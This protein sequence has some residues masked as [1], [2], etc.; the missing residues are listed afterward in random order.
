MNT[1]LN[2]INPFN[3]KEIARYNIDQPSTVKFKLERSKEASIRWASVSIRQRA[4]YLKTLADYLQKNKAR[5]AAIATAEM[6]KPLT[7]SITELEKSA[8]TLEYY[9]EH[10]AQFLEPELV[11][12]EAQKSFVSFQPLGT[13]LAIM[14]WNFPYW[15]VFRAMGPILLGGNTML[16]KHA[17]NVTGCAIAIEKALLEAG[18]PEGIFQTL[19]VPSS[20][21]EPVIASKYIHAVTFTG[22]TA[23]GAKV[24]ALAAT[25]LKKQ[26]L[27]LGGSDAYVILS[28]ADLKNTVEVSVQSRLNNTGQS[29]IAAKRFVVDQKV[30]K[31]FT[32]QMIALMQAR[33]YGDPMNASMQMGPMA[34]LDLRD[35]LHKQVMRSVEKGAKIVC[36]GFIPD[37]EGAF[38]PPTVLT[39]VKKGMPAYDEELFGPVAAIIEAKDEDDAIRIANDSPFGLGAAIFSR[40]IKKAEQIA[41][42]RLQAGSVFVN[43]FV[44]SDPRLPFGGIKQSGYG[45][46]LSLYGLREFVNIKTIFIR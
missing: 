22:S 43:D 8:R 40:D 16:L 24:A 45:R 31:T 6:G 42:E 19:I 4:A 1:T 41:T 10:A 21:I 15:Q 26:V 34:R 33:T 39:N 38:Y 2:S 3:G 46:E 29:C 17:S 25:H 14:P 7:Q 23:A 35:E 32:E 28:D 9:A 12:T 30:I 18:L 37:M 13:I 11:S 27:E 5:M 44:R 36:G 20:E